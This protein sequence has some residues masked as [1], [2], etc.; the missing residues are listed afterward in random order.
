ME[1]F[2][3]V[4]LLDVIW[5]EESFWS[6]ESWGV[7]LDNLTIWKFIISLVFVRV[8]SLFLGLSWVEGDETE[9]LLDFS[10]NLLPS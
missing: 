4:T 7:D 6:H 10:D 1:T 8:G 2:D 3:L 5:E 9:F